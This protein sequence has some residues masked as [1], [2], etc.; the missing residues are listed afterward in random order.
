MLACA[1]RLLT[2]A[3][4]STPP[5]GG[6]RETISTSTRPRGLRIGDSGRTWITEE[7]ADAG[8]KDA[9]SG[10]R[11]IGAVPV[12]LFDVGF[13]GDL[14][15]GLGLGDG[16]AD[17]LCG[18]SFV[19][20]VVLVLRLRLGDLGGEGGD[21][22]LSSSTSMASSLSFFDALMDVFL[23]LARFTGRAFASSSFSSPAAGGPIFPL[24]LALEIEILLE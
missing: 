2:L 21:T 15:L 5:L 10:L 19:A 17:D 6:D 11:W 4:E 23:A 18:L 13:A 16:G 12:L 1:R 24:P 7:S 14:A 9:D 22:L 3:L 20:D 8:T